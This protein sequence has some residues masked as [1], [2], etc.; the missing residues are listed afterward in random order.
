[1]L[2]SEVLNFDFSKKG[3]DEPFTAG[4]MDGISGIQT[5]RDRVV[6]LGGRG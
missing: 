5:F 4:E 1:V 3:Y 2:L 6:T